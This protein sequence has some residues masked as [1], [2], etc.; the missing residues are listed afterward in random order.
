MNTF[1]SLNII[2]NLFS[3]NFI[4]L[5]ILTFFFSNKNKKFQLSEILRE[6]DGFSE[7][8]LL[9]VEGPELLH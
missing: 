9:N 2:S 3:K 7:C 5:N 8:L 1:L 6:I 4:N